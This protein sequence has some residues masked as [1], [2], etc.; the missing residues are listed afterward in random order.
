M[1][2]DPFLTVSGL[3]AILH[4]IVADETLALR[5]VPVMG[6][7]SGRSARG[8]HCYFTL[9]DANAQISCVMF[10]APKDSVP[11]DGAMALVSG[12]ID[13]YEP[14]GKISIK[15]SSVADVGIGALRERLDRLTKA[16]EAEGLFDES[17]KKR[18]PEYP[19]NVGIVTS[20]DGAAL[21]DVLSTLRAR[22]SRQ[23]LTIFDIRVQ[24]SRCVR[25][26][27][28]ALREADGMGLDVI[29]L[30]RG[31]GSFED[32]FPF[33]DEALVRAI[34][35]MNTPVVSAIGHE[36]DF[37]LCDFVA[38]AREITP[39]AGAKRI[40]VD[41]KEELSRTIRALDSMRDLAWA[42]Y[43][44]NRKRL[45][46]A[47]NG[48]AGGANHLLRRCASEIEARLSNVSASADRIAKDKA[49]EI[50]GML[51]RLESLN[52][53]KLLK[54]GYFRMTF[55]SEPIADTSAIGPGDRVAIYGVTEK[56]TAEILSKEKI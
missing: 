54:A 28:E 32:L 23:N 19:A 37:S 51:D 46:N 56:L 10:D 6:E 3:N 53:T 8:R 18:I 9:K 42:L 15:V 24:G 40:S 45:E 48:I 26:A 25:D 14:Y 41:S 35:A 33:S 4:R 49:R 38:D 31:G 5:D 34:Y 43:R 2:N 44:D 17:H 22:N 21:Q 12:R 27:V 47:L 52:P 1:P 50:S 30:T 7:I 13:Y 55:R 29:L 16:L 20:R 36:T 39:T 11:P